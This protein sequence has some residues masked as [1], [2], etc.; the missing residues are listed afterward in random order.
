[1][2]DHVLEET[3]VGLDP[4]D[5][6]LLQGAVHDMGRLLEGQPPGTHLDQEGVVVG[7][8]LGAGE[9]ITRVEANAAAGG[10]AIGGQGAEVRGKIVCRVFRGDA[11]LDGIAAHVDGGLG[12]DIDFGVG[13][14][15]PL[16]HQYLVLHQVTPGD[17]LRH[18]ML[19][20]D[21]GVHLDEVVVPFA[22]HEELD[23]TGIEVPDMAG[24][25]Q[26][27]SAELLPLGLGKA[28]C[29]G[30]LHH[31]LVAALH[32]AVTLE[33]VHQVAMGIAEDLDLD[34][35]GVLDVALQENRRVAEGGPGL[36]GGAGK[37][38]KELLL[39]PGHAHAATATAGRC[40]DD[41]RIA[42]VLGKPEGLL[43]FLD[44]V[45]RPWNDLHTRSHGSLAAG[46]LVPE[47]THHVGAGA[48]ECYARC[49]AALGKLGILRE[50]AV[51][52]MDGIHIRLDGQG[53][54]LVNPQVGVDGCLP[55]ADQIRLVRLV[56]MQRKLVLF[57]VYCH[58]ADAELGAGTEY[59]DGDLA[60]VCRHY[61]SES[62]LFHLEP[63]VFT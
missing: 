12:R 49:L 30:K 54:D 47:G 17:H 57:R 29:R 59:A 37:T 32:R 51:T 2:G 43:L 16:G 22:V 41:D 21:T 34:M 27:G 62:F 35:L 5:T 19:H 10:G 56:A 11:T 60:A 23:G 33:E 18:R 46:H 4:A 50:E 40:L 55:L 25:L 31:L 42:I 58:G 15:V 44:G 20:L 53:D 48:D 24:D 28:E 38:F 7:G 14:L 61:F 36:A 45:L 26:G 13:Q 1:M 3:D 39:V 8:D 63:P 9:G 52:G 6:E